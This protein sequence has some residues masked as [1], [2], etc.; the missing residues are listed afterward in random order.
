M[1]PAIELI[2]TSHNPRV[3]GGTGIFISL[4]A[5]HTEI[6]RWLLANGQGRLIWTDDFTAVTVSREVTIK[7]KCIRL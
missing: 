4:A 2:I 5:T 7:L 6:S 1:T 3:H